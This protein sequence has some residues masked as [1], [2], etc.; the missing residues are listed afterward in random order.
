MWYLFSHGFDV[1]EG[2][3][4]G[5]GVHDDKALPIPDVEISHGGKL[6]CPCSV[7]DLQNWG[8]AINLNLLAVEVFYCRI[9]L[10]HEAPCKRRIQWMKSSWWNELHQIQERQTCDKLDS[11]GTLAHTTRTQDH[12]FKFPHFVSSLQQAEMTSPLLRLPPSDRVNTHD[13]GVLLI[14]ILERVEKTNTVFTR[15]IEE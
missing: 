2:L 13:D 12:H 8:W 5:D 6:L 1:L 4:I 3:M 10:L 15:G 7:Q 9:I 14:C 11:Q